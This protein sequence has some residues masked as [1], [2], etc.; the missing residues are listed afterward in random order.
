MQRNF[1]KNKKKQNSRNKNKNLTL[2]KF[3]Q[4]VKSI[5]FEH[6]ATM[7]CSRVISVGESITRQVIC[8]SEFNECVCKMQNKK[9]FQVKRSVTSLTICILPIAKQCQFCT[10]LVLTI[11]ITFMIR[12]RPFSYIKNNDSFETV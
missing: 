11:K 10:Q 12:S 8:D 5:L 4:T 3:G 2:T 1:K 9:Q 6:L 7:R